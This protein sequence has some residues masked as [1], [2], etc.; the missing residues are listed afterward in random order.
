MSVHLRKK[1]FGD[2]NKQTKNRPFKYQ[3]DLYEK[4]RRRREIIENLVVHPNDS[5][6][7]KKAKAKRAETIRAKREFE[8][9]TSKHGFTSTLRRRGSFIEYFKKLENSKVAENTIENWTKTRKHILKF[10]NERITFEEIDKVWLE[11][12]L[13]YLKSKLSTNSVITYFANI[14]ETLKQAYKDK[15]IDENPCIHLKAIPPEEKEMTYLTEKEVQK[16]FATKSN[17]PEVKRAFLFECSTGVRISDIKNLKWENIKGNRLFF[18]QIKTGQREQFYLSE[19]A[20]K[21]LGE[22]GKDTEPIFKLSS[23]TSS[24][25]RAIK[26]WVKKAGINK[27]ITTHIGR[28]TFATSLITQGTDIYGVRK[29]MGHKDLRST[30][31]YA[32]FIDE[33]QEKAVNSLPKYN[34]DNF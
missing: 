21:L 33:E 24:I 25:N 7:E 20:Q 9:N 12:F 10:A 31:K 29:L 19:D 11:G 6:E 18:K 5:S 15:I 22:R 27:I 14:R 32:K 16:L 34:F 17:S 3:L 1:Y 13:K 2:K 23:H 28:H 8:L 30:Q 4:G 26:V